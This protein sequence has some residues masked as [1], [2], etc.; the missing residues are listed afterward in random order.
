MATSLSFADSL[1][2][3]KGVFGAKTEL[4]FATLY[5]ESYRLNGAFVEVLSKTNLEKLSRYLG[6]AFD[7]DAARRVF[8][9]ADTGAERLYFSEN[10]PAFSLD[11]G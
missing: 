1:A 9:H 3:M 6:G 5:G 2:L 10:P 8:C 11:T 4:R 7:P